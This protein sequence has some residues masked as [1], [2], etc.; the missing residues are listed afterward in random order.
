VKPL[1]NLPAKIGQPDLFLSGFALR[2]NDSG[3]HCQVRW[4]RAVLD[5][6]G[7]AFA[8]WTGADLFGSSRLLLTLVDS[9]FRITIPRLLEYP[10]GDVE[11]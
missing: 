9:L 3:H 8:D 7:L 10:D 11:T 4:C 2:L 6:D 5:T 1:Q